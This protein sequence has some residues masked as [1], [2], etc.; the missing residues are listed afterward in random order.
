M[1]PQQPQR[2]TVIGM[3]GR[4][5]ERFL[6]AVPP[7][8][9][10]VYII[11]REGKDD[12]A[13]HVKKVKDTLE[14]TRSIIAKVRE[15]DIFDTTSSFRVVDQIMAEA[16]RGGARL[17]VVLG[18]GTN[19]CAGILLFAG[20]QKG[21]GA[22]LVNVSDFK[23]GEDIVITQV[24]ALILPIHDK[25]DDFED[26]LVAFNLIAEGHNGRPLSVRQLKAKLKRAGRPVRAFRDGKPKQTTAIVNAFVTKLTKGYVELCPADEHAAV[27]EPEDLLCR[28][29]DFGSRHQRAYGHRVPATATEAAT[30]PQAEAAKAKTRRRGALG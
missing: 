21:V 6:A 4:S 12:C 3:V 19:I 23:P 15:C 18:T 24:D 28:L 10:E 7:D 9:A 26:F 30:S 1:G 2:V 14:E 27:H 22:E 20:S 11:T 5:P 8:V 25:D 16:L 17:R 29:S 13:E